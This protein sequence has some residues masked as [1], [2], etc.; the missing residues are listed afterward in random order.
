MIRTFVDKNEVSEPDT[1]P[2][3]APDEASGK[4]T[5]KTRKQASPSRSTATKNA[6]NLYQWKKRTHPCSPR[7]RRHNLQIMPKIHPIDVQNGM[8]KRH[9]KK[10]E[11]IRPQIWLWAGPL[12]ETPITWTGISAQYRGSTKRQ[13]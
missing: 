5:L 6:S 10:R 3:D 11:T 7:R 12:G 1:F 2:A 9:G 4:T 8:E 13:V